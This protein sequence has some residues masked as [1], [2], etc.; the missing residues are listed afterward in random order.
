MKKDEKFIFLIIL[1]ACIVFLFT[2]TWFFYREGEGRASG[3]LFNVAPG[4]SAKEI[5]YRL[6]DEKLIPHPFYFLFWTKVLQAE[7]KIKAGTYRL[8]PSFSS[9]SILLALL[10]GRAYTVKVVIP[11]GLT[12]ERVAEILKE[13]GLISKDKFLNIV[14]N[15]KCD[16]YLF[17]DTYF[18]PFNL[19]EETIVETMVKQ[20]N[21]EFTPQF[22][23]RARELGLDKR[24]IIILASLIEKEVV[25]EEERPYISGVFHNRL[26][27]GW[28]LES[29]ATVQYAL[30]EHR[31]RL[32][33]HD[34]KINSP[35]NTYLYS[36]LPPGPICN[37][38]RAS[39]KAA[40]YPAK[41]DDLFFVAQGNGWHYF[42]RYYN[43]H[44]KNKQ[45]RKK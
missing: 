26:K 45:L 42:S 12:T 40:L 11:E 10:N 43:Q 29:C 18:L 7:K 23:E 4:M 22:S 36:G 6:K 16:G 25:K 38:G 32:T 17:P 1:I 37:P 5:A 13:K 30:G 28:L 24:K 21:K 3:A 9:L 2:V 8:K 14:A 19:G 34:L 27:K 31:P 15:L 20:F 35:Y 44:L 33:Y 41:T 39:I